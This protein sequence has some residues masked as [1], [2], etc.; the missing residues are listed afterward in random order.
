MLDRYN[1]SSLNYQSKIR[2]DTLIQN[3][4]L[5][6]L[7]NILGTTITALDIELKMKISR[8]EYLESKTNSKIF[9]RVW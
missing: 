5:K 9:K 8:I 4:I 3:V 1:R 6:E 7:R 2:Y